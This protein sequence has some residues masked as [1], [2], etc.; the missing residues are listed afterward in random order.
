MCACVCVRICVCVYACVYAVCVHVCVHMCVYACV[1]AVCVC[2][3]VCIQCVCVHVCMQCVCVCMCVCAGVRYVHSQLHIEGNTENI[4]LLHFKVHS[5]SGLVVSLKDVPTVSAA[6]R[7]RN[8]KVAMSDIA[9]MLHC[10]KK[11][12]IKKLLT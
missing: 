12:I 9:D 11:C 5:Y 3:C 8:N 7:V 6:T 4:E 1:Y 2:M 10:C